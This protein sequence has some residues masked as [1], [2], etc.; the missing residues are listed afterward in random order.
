L[1]VKLV[2]VVAL[3]IGCQQGSGPVPA[4]SDV[5]G[6]APKLTIVTPPFDVPAPADPVIAIGRGV[7]HACVVR[8]SG[9]V[10][11]WGQP[12][13]C[14]Q[15]AVPAPPDGRVRRLPEIS[16]AVAI[17]PGARCFVRRTGEVECLD[18]ETGKLTPIAGLDHVRAATDDGCYLLDN[19]GASCVDQDGVHRLKDVHDAVLIAMANRMTCT[20]RKDGALFCGRRDTA[21]AKVAGVDH[22]RALAMAHVVDDTIICVLAN[23]ARCFT[24][25]VYRDST[26]V[27]PVT[28]RMPVLE[29]AFAGAT[30][31]AISLT[32]FGEPYDLRGEV[33]ALVA[34]KVV[35]VDDQQ[36]STMI[37]DAKLLAPGCVVRAKGAVAC[38]GDNR[39]AVLAQPTTIGR[40]DVPPTPVPGI[41]N[42]AAVAA[43]MTETWALTRDGRA[44]HWGNTGDRVVVRAPS[45]I[46]FAGDGFGT[47]KLVQVVAAPGGI[48][49]ARGELGHVW[50]QFSE[51]R[52]RTIAQLQTTDV[53][54]V[55]IRSFDVAVLDHADGSQEL[56]QEL[57]GPTIAAVH[58]ITNDGAVQTVIIN[59]L[60]LE[61]RRLAGGQ[62]SCGK[63]AMPQLA[64]ATLLATGMAEACALVEGRVMCWGQQL[65]ARAVNGI[66]AATALVMGN[67]YGCA[68]EN[69]RVVCWHFTKDNAPIQP[70]QIIASGV[71]SLSLGGGNRGQWQ[72]AHVVDDGPRPAGEYGCAVMTDH[73]V[74]CWGA[75]IAG[76]LLDSS[77]RSTATPIGIRLE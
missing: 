77:F 68:I 32:G 66:T 8:A 28:D 35:V 54:H 38:W 31:I 13:S 67:D 37:D 19:G 58:K 41:T 60:D 33:E 1:P 27:E 39:G 21:Y 40:M 2:V 16:D 18:A 73:T 75:N 15:C 45:E 52:E 7:Q 42:I 57:Y 64:G 74:Q 22:V 43:G 10:D 46:K 29:P 55:A 49:C 24:V 71:L 44:L 65:E 61:C 4:K 50:C 62:V 26:T 17:S 59:D 36:T 5:I 30:Q 25:Q 69:G 63:T 23:Q 70:T 9:A 3:L 48:G 56:S 11:C 51:R 34:G 76:E 53:T 72:E 47:E 14:T 6:P 12:R 20:V